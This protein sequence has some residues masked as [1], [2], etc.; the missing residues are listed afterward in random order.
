MRAMGLPGRRKEGETR[1]P[2]GNKRRRRPKNSDVDGLRSVCYSRAETRELRVGCLV[3]CPIDEYIF[4]MYVFFPLHVPTLAK[5]Q[6]TRTRA[7]R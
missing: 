7:H 4:F 2:R 5:R 3:E 6:L 1:E